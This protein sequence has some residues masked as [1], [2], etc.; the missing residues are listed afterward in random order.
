MDGKKVRIDDKV[1]EWED[2]RKKISSYLEYKREENDN[3][4]AYEG[5]IKDSL[6]CGFFYFTR[7]QTMIILSVFDNFTFV[8]VIEL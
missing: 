3:T 7:T 4:L 5:V 6:C 2:I 8:L 1:F